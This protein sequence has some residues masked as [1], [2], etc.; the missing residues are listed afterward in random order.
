LGLCGKDC[1]L[2]EV[3][4]DGKQKEEVQGGSKRH[5]ISGVL[6]VPALHFAV[7]PL[8]LDVSCRMLHSIVIGERPPGEVRH[9]WVA[10]KEQ[11]GCSLLAMHKRR[12][13]GEEMAVAQTLTIYSSD[14]SRIALLAGRPSFSSDVPVVMT[15]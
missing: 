6:T 4:D 15:S 10:H 1:G 12:N 7:S 2:F 13:P 3:V 5:Y 9:T 8:P 14:E 11:V